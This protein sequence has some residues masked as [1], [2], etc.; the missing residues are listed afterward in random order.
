M[1]TLLHNP[2]FESFIRPNGH[3]EFTEF[4]KILP[5][6]DQEKVLVFI[7]QIEREGLV[8]AQRLQWVKKIEDNLF[9]IRAKLGHNIQRVFYFHFS[10]SR[11]IITHGFSKKTA[12]TP[13]REIR[14]AEQLRSEFYGGTK[15]GY[16]QV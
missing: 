7:Q 10:G 12:K 5:Q 11:Y 8:T 13:Q 16:H 9:E 4:L 14:H 6:K 1:V 15:Y 2:K 3:N